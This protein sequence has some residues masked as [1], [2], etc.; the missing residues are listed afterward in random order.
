MR[1]YQRIYDCVRQ[2]PEGRVATYAQIARLAGGCSARQVGY[3]LAA[4][5]D[6]TDIPWQRV[7]NSR[8]EISPRNS[9]DGHEF[10]RRLLKQEGVEFNPDGR[11]DLEEFGWRRAALS[12]GDRLP[13]IK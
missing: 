8:G 1:L 9:G 2:V 5:T 6:G 12:P 3:A 13:G 7:I 11:I 10:Q 4:L